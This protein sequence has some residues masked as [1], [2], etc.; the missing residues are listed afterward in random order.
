[1]LGRL[2]EKY[3]R[4]TMTTLP[5]L[6]LPKIMIIE[7]MHFCVLWLNSFPVKSGVSEKWSPR[8]L[9]SR[10]WLDAKLHCKTP[11][12]AY[13][14]MHKDPDITY[15]MEPR[16]KWGICMGPIGNLQGSYKFMSLTT[17]TKI[18]WHKFTEMQM[19]EAVMKQ[20]KKWQ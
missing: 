8:E 13:C 15:T 17:R 19:T 6:T 18:A 2:R 5:Y 20:I 11:S 4:G 10:H 12:G 16:T 9:I 14:E 7:L 1:M 3:A